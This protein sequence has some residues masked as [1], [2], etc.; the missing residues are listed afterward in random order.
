MQLQTASR[1]RAKIKMGLQGPS[2][3]GK[4]YSAL[5]I[6]FG[7]TNDWSKV[8][9]IDT[10]NHSADLYANLGE[11]KVLSLSAPFS[12][13]RYIEAVEACLQAGVDVIIIDSIS[14][15]WEGTG[16]ILDM[17][18]QMPGNSFTAWAKLTP[19]HNAFIQ[20]MLQS[21][22]HIIANM[23]TKQDYVLVDKNGKMV[24]EKV[25]LKGITREGMDYEFTVVFELDIKHMASVSKDRTFLFAD[26]PEFKITAETGRKILEWCTSG[27]EISVDDVSKRIGECKRIDELLTLYK[28]F[29]QFKEVLKQEY[30]QQ[31]RRILINQHANQSFN[32]KATM[33]G[34]E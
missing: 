7:L 21:P 31:K 18:S 11:Y 6:A 33:N 19:R 4:T 9:V 16:G 3:S 29:P 15:E 26:K 12:P 28:C 13:E 24:P 10:E 23:R 20:E 30:E 27:A 14:H 5:L 1:K 2:G 32:S 25:G 17:H 8:A 34:T 22:I